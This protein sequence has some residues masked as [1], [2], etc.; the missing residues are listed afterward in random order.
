MEPSEH[1]AYTTGMKLQG[2]RALLT[3]VDHG[4][5][6]EAALELGTSQSAMS[7]AI[8]ELEEELGVRLLDRGRFGAVPT[9]FGRNVVVHARSVQRAVDAIREEAALELGSL[10][11]TLRIG[12]FRS[13]ATTVLPRAIAKLRS[14]CPGLRIDVQ[15]VSSHCTDPTA[16]LHAGTAD[17]AITMRYLAEDAVFW[18]LMKDRYVAVVRQDFMHRAEAI[19]LGTLLDHPVILSDGPCAWPARQALTEQDPAFHP[20]YEIAEDSTILGLVE[21]GLGVAVMPEL[22]LEPFPQGLRRLELAEPMYRSI[23]LALTAGAIKIPGVRAFLRTLHELYPE[24]E[25]PYLGDVARVGA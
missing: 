9:E 7:Y 23:G 25:V 12:A 19:S 24:S 4:S 8:A 16:A 1:A 22:T 20:A 15:E 17:A 21:Q 5:F 10:S 6:S 3:I 2:L 18:E 13:A 14:R 11:G